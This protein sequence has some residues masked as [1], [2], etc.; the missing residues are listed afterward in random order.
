[1]TFDSTSCD[2]TTMSRLWPALE[3]DTQV[4]EST[5]FQRARRISCAICRCFKQSQ[6]VDG[7]IWCLIRP[8]VGVLIWV[9][10]VSLPKPRHRVH[11]SMPVPLVL[12]DGMGFPY[13][14]IDTVRKLP[15]IGEEHIKSLT[16]RM[17]AAFVNW[18]TLKY[19][20][21]S[22]QIQFCEGWTE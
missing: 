8:A 15:G 5:P 12:P 6:S 1:M 13:Q 19:K 4:E 18:S 9:S 16:E 11:I 2:E 7:S 10:L 20:I 3:C 17:R 21:R 22:Y 14:T